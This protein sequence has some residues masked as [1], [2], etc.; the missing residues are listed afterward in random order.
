MY[1]YRACY[2][3]ICLCYTKLHIKDDKVNTRIII[4]NWPNKGSHICIKKNTKRETGQ[5]KHA[6][7]LYILTSLLLSIH[8]SYMY[9]S[10][11]YIDDGWGKN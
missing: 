2:T 1:I 3:Y 4:Y 8:Q 6:T 9:V 11:P 7:K 10:Q 5:S